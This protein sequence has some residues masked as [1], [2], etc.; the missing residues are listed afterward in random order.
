M[1][2]PLR[3][4]ILEDNPSDAQLMLHEIRRV[5]FDP[6]ATVVETEPDYRDKLLARPEIILSD[7]SMPE[8]DALRALEILKESDLD[9]PVIIV[10]GSIGEDRAVQVMLR[11][12]S[13]YVVKDRIGRL[14]QAV[15]QALEKKRL[16]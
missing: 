12:A 15:T 7:F 5:G 11:G 6:L 3:L 8:F 16:R 14:G 4:R 10:S 13:D 9:I 2:I 1:A